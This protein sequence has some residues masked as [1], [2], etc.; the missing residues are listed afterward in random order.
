MAF[1]MTQATLIKKGSYVIFDGEACKVMDAQVSKSGKHGHAKMRIVAIGLIDGKKRDVVLPGHDNVEVPLIEKKN[2]QVLSISGTTAN[3]M[4]TES[5]ETFTLEIPEEL[6]E[7]V[8]DNCNVV[9]WNILD[10]KIM[11]QLKSA[12]EESE[13]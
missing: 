4:D 7:T 10:Q 11:K 8:T 6:R 5:F 1:K 9:Y 13:E 2:A 12:A 3:V